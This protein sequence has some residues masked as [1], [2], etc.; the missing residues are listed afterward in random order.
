M[1]AR[2]GVSA[3]EMVEAGFSAVEDPF[4]GRDNLFHGVR[5]GP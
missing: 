1:G 3:A 4:S 2:N 5:A